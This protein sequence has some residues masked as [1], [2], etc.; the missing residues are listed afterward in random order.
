MRKISRYSFKRLLG[1]CQTTVGDTFFAVP[2]IRAV[3]N[4]RVRC[5]CAF[6][7]VLDT[8]IGL[9]FRALHYNEANNNEI[10]HRRREEKHAI[11]RLQSH[12]R[13]Y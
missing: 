12:D 13:I 2:C 7:T 8:T 10:A 5:A 1:K 4:R 11:I 9:L 6:F 3:S